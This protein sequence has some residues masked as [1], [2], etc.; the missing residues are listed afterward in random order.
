MKI[1]LSTYSLLNAIKSGE[2]DVLDVVDWIAENGG[3]HMEIVPYGF[4]LVDNLELADQVRNRAEE[5][6]IEISN[7]SMPANFVQETEEEFNA[8]VARL[9]EH[10]DLLNRMGIK[11]MRHDVTAFTVPPE[12]R[13]IEYFENSL[14]QITE[15]SRQ[16]ADYAAQ[17]GITTTIENHGMAV[18]HSDRV[19]RVVR[20]VD[21]PNFK[22]TLDVGNFMCVDENSIVGVKKNLP[23][24]SLIHFKDFYFRPYYQDPGA[25]KWFKT[26]NDNFLKGAIVGHGD[27]E[28]RE[29]VKLIKASGYDGNITLEFEGM[30]ECREASKIG[31]D[32]IR[33]FWDEA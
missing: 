10:V 28:I 9:K 11:H 8:E 4:T 16:I 33:R 22:T 20:A 26:A 31:M 7:Y 15:G 13:T 27:I 5:K 21:R 17:F 32:N 3:E 18:Q 12:K 2:M 24:A 25:G 23:F 6:G 19:Q 30:E 1:G 29:I 14:P